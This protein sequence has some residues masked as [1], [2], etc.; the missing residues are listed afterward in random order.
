MPVQGYRLD[1]EGVAMHL[2]ARL[3]LRVFSASGG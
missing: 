1:Q 3:S 2:L